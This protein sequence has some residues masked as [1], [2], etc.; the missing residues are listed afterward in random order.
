MTWRG[1]AGFPQDERYWFMASAARRV[2]F[3]H[4]QLERARDGVDTYSGDPAEALAILADVEF[5]LVAM[6]RAVEMAVGVNGRFETPTTLPAVVEAKRGAIKALR[7]AYEHID[8]R[9]LGIVEGKLRSP[10]EAHTLFVV[11]GYGAALVERR[12][13]ACRQWTSGSTRRRPRSSTRSSSSFAR[14]GSSC[15]TARTA[16]GRHCDT[17]GTVVGFAFARSA[18]ASGR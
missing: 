14:A 5:A 16:P 3:A 13:V 11:G 4:R 7:D 2:D 15:A 6:H 17:C 9:A 12:E 18:S 10:T 1:V 8:E